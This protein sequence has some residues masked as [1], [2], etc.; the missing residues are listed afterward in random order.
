MKKK[1]RLAAVLAAVAACAGI[2]VTSFADEAA[3]VRGGLDFTIESPTMLDPVSVFVKSA[4]D[5]SGNEITIKEK[6]MNKD[7]EQ[8]VNLEFKQILN[9]G[10]SIP[11]ASECNVHAKMDLEPESSGNGLIRMYFTGEQNKSYYALHLRGGGDPSNMQMWEVL[12]CKRDSSSSTRYYFELSSFSPVAII[13]V[14]GPA[15]E[16]L[17]ANGTG[18]NNTNSVK[19][20][21]GGAALKSGTTGKTE[22]TGKPG[23]TEEPGTIEEP[24]T[25]EQQGSSQQPGTISQ[26]SL[27]D[28]KSPRTGEF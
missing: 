20:P 23:I 15:L 13:E 4:V 8:Y 3:A 5:A 26:N 18:G 14:S 7:V 27:S 22:T 9:I 6:E 28:K 10:Y 12:E 2:S 17:A 16:P 25:T 11:S 19:Y 1:K 24:E 21:Y